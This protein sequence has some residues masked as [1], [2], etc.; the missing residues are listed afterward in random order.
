[1]TTVNRKDLP[2]CYAEMMQTEQHHDHEIIMVNDVVRWK[3]NEGVREV[4]DMCDLNHMIADM[5][6]KSIG[7]NDEPYRR[8]Y[9]NMGYSLS[10]YWEIFYWDLNNGEADEYKPPAKAT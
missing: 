2:D 7:K 6:K 9:R 4:V 8:L 10:G 3:V 1:M 5:Q